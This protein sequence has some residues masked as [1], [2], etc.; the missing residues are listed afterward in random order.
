[1]GARPG[2]RGLVQR[3]LADEPSGPAPP[4][5]PAPTGPI[6]VPRPPVPSVDDESVRALLERQR[7]WIRA[8]SAPMAAEESAAPPSEPAPPEAPPEGAKG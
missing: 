3:R 5:A 7:R 1:V 6:L 4:A 2:A 8:S